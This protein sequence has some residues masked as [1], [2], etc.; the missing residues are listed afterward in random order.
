[1]WHQ[2]VWNQCTFVWMKKSSCFAS[3]WCYAEDYGKCNLVLLGCGVWNW[4]QT[5]GSLQTQVFSIEVAN[6]EWKGGNGHVICFGWDWQWEH[7]FSTFHWL[8]VTQ[9]ERAPFKDWSCKQHFTERCTRAVGCPQTLLSNNAQSEAGKAWTNHLQ[10]HCIKG[11]HTQPHHCSFEVPLS[12]HD[13]V[14][15]W[16]CETHDLAA[17]KKN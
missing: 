8:K 15:K 17:H 1:M 9:T 11:E 13:W 3:G 5:M 12:K 7:R 16:C 14:Q 2:D 10:T 6:P 4:R